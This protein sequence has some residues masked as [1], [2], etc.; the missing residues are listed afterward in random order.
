MGKKVP[1]DHNLHLKIFPETKSHH[2]YHLLSSYG[3]PGLYILPLKQSSKKGI[4]S[5]IEQ[6]AKETRGWRRLS[7]ESQSPDSQAIIS[8]GQSNF[9]PVF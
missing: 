6:T 7:C 2:N 3:E 8:K 5:P 4:T 9:Q 1:G